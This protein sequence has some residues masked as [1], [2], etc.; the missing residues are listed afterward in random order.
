VG[1]PATPGVM[2]H[3][4][5][6]RK[7]KKTFVWWCWYIGIYWHVSSEPLEQWERSEYEHCEKK[8]KNILQEDVESTDP[9][10]EEKVITVR[11]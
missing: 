6:E 4:R 10:K 2:A 11:P 5:K 8:E 9:G 1:A 3:R 7:N